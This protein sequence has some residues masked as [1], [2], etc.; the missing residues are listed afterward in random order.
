[1][2]QHM[3]QDALC[4]VEFGLVH[5]LQPAH[6]EI[7][8]R[9]YCRGFNSRIPSDALYNVGYLAEALGRDT[10]DGENGYRQC[11][12]GRGHVESL[13]SRNN[14]V[15]DRGDGDCFCRHEWVPENFKARAGQHRG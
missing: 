7:M 13:L 4:L 6:K 8:F 10:R 5:G 2:Y 15:G 14:Q 11:F 9:A 3:R 12:S 1:M